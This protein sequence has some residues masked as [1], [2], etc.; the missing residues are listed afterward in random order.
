MKQSY[1]KWYICFFWFSFNPRTVYE[2]E[3]RFLYWMFFF[4]IKYWNVQWIKWNILSLNELNKIWN[5]RWKLFFLERY[6]ND[7]M[8]NIVIGK[9]TF[10]S[11]DFHFTL[12]WQIFLFRCV[13]SKADFYIKYSFILST[14]VQYNNII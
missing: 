3:S 10:I 11:F 7:G 14:L 8:W 4:Y 13:Y 12:E 5:T 9:N 2:L 1:W 6:R